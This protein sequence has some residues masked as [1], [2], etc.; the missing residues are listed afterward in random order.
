MHRPTDREWRGINRS[1]FISF[2]ES[3]WKYAPN[4][5][6]PESRKNLVN[7][8]RIWEEKKIIL[9]QQKRSFFLFNK[10][11]K[12]PLQ[13]ANHTASSPTRPEQPHT[14]RVNFIYYRRSF[15]LR[16]K[17]S[18]FH[19]PQSQKEILVAWTGVDSGNLKMTIR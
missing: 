3:I 2:H 15:F 6:L 14:P 1:R 7:L 16:A 13:K 18:A 19:W 12:L 10:S 17:F 4:R 11:S 9:G 5:L 8:H